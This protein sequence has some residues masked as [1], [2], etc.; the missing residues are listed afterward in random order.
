MQAQPEQSDYRWLWDCS[1]GCSRRTRNGVAV[2][3]IGCNRPD[4]KQERGVHLIT[5]GPDMSASQIDH[6]TVTAASLSV[7]AEFVHQTLGVMPQA[8]GK[9]PRMGTHN[10]LLRLGAS[11]FLEII[12]PD[13]EGAA[14]GRPRWFGLDNLRPSA[15]PS[16][17]AWVIRTDDIKSAASGSSESLG[18]IELMTRGDIEWS[19]TIPADGEIPLDGA[20]PALI[21]WHTAVHPAA[22]LEDY[23]LS[24]A[25]L[26]IFHPQPA[27]IARLLQSIDCSGPVK[28]SP[29]CD[30]M[31]S[32]LVAHIDTPQGVR[33]LSFPSFPS[34]GHVFFA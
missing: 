16:L 33:V 7:G 11:L 6:I 30:G 5:E 28:V 32:C 26:E 8:G 14:P 15:P 17:A 19:I 31:P 20:A 18:D 13:P 2:V 24:L 9:H 25:G 12:S 1:D 27:R 22:M 29:A 4:K 3:I 34:S 23:G 10:L 21:E